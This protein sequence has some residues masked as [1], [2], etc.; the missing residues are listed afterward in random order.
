MLKVVSLLHASS[1]IWILQCCWHER[2]S[3]F[4]CCYWLHA[5]EYIRP[6]AIM[7]H[8]LAVEATDPLCLLELF[9]DVG[10]STESRKPLK[11][12]SGW[13]ESPSAPP[14]SL[15]GFWEPALLLD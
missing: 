13:E 4:A 1:Y 2:G 7:L 14:C 11:L 10:M 9:V 8:Y 3:P 6:I 5:S 15:A 12:H